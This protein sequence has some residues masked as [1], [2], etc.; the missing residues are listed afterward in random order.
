MTFLIFS[1]KLLTESWCSI[2]KSVNHISDHGFKCI[3]W[4]CCPCWTVGGVGGGWKFFVF[5]FFWYKKTFQNRFMFLE[6]KFI[7]AHPGAPREDGFETCKEMNSICECQMFSK[8]GMNCAHDDFTQETECWEERGVEFA[9]MH[10][11]QA[12]LNTQLVGCEQNSGS[13]DKRILKN[14]ASQK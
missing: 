4:F 2:S 5:L 3:S 11:F 9:M 12:M 8:W 7:R 6:V 13:C 10:S 1:D 14:F